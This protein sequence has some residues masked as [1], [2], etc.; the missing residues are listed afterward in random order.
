M[1][2]PCENIDDFI[3]GIK[4]HYTVTENKHKQGQCVTLYNDYKECD[5]KITFI[6]H[7]ANEHI[8]HL[9][10]IDGSE[11]N[12]DVVSNYYGGTNLLD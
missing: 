5:F 12:R 9:R 2:L 4:H 8:L 7:Y 1:R 3:N 10:K 6:L 11:Y